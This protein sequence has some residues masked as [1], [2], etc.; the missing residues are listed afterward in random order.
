MKD[1]LITRVFD[2][3]YVDVLA[4]LTSVPHLEET[5][6]RHDRQVFIVTESLLSALKAWEK[7]QGAY[8]CTICLFT[9]DNEPRWIDAKEDITQ[10]V[11]PVNRVE[12]MVHEGKSVEKLET[13]LQKHLRTD[14]HFGELYFGEQLPEFNLAKK[15]ETELRQG[16]TQRYCLALRNQKNGILPIQTIVR[17]L[18]DEQYFFNCRMQ[19]FLLSLKMPHQLRL[20]L[21]MREVL[22]P[23]FEIVDDEIEVRRKI[24]GRFKGPGVVK[25]VKV[26][27]KD[28]FTVSP[29]NLHEGEFVYV[30]EVHTPEHG[31]D[32]FVTRMIFARPPNVPVSLLEH[33]DAEWSKQN[34]DAINS[35]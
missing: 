3:L 33:I 8:S 35:R 26:E 12:I 15:I 21:L 34:I 1:F 4:Q 9:E 2:Y 20:S 13:L 19:T 28:Q 32:R 10:F 30:S 5:G 27:N 6:L 16:H 14:K 24:L 25:S 23:A 17:N 22:V 31:P 11:L 7:L 18:R 29:K